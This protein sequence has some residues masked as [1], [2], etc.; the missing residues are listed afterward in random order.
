MA[1]AKGVT[2]AVL[3]GELARSQPLPA[4]VSLEEHPTWYNLTRVECAVLT[5]IAE[6]DFARAEHREARLRLALAADH[7]LWAPEALKVNPITRVRWPADQSDLL[8]S[9]QD[10]FDAQSR[11]G[12]AELGICRE[13]WLTTIYALF[14]TRYVGALN[15]R[16]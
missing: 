12:V 2:P 1:K 11:S 8:F 9:V 15:A 4:S 13:I 3:L 7:L 10:A 16:P 14:L 5:E 6:Q